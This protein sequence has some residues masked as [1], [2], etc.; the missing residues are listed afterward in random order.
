MGCALG[1][2]CAGL[3]L[4]VATP[5]LTPAIVGA[6]GTE[7][8]LIYLLTVALPFG[9]GALLTGALFLVYEEAEARDG[10]P[11][12]SGMNDGWRWS[13]VRIEQERPPRSK[14]E[15]HDARRPQR[16]ITWSLGMLALIIMILMIGPVLVRLGAGF[17]TDRAGTVSASANSRRPTPAHYQADADKLRHN[18]SEESLRCWSDECRSIR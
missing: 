3:L 6:P 7:E 2:L 15:P 14:P 13:P 12:R 10:K 11:E 18:R 17:A 1:I 9:V 8:R 4:I 16:T 5:L